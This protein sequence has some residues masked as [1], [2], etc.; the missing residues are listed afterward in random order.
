MRLQFLGAAQQVTGSKTRVTYRDRTYLV[1]CG[2][3][4]G[5]RRLREQNW[6]DL[7]HAGGYAG[8][9]L[10]H[11]HIDHC[12]YLPRLVKQGFHGPIYCTA[13]TAA[14]VR[15]LLADAAHLQEE[16]AEDAN[17]N[18]YS[19]H[20]PALP[21]FTMEDV[22][23]TVRLLRVVPR[24]QWLDIGPDLTCRFLRSGHLLGSSFVQLSFLSGEQSRVVTFSGDLGSERSHIIK[25]PVRITETDYLVM[26]G[27]YGDRVHHAEGQEVA[28]ART[29]LS[30]YA[31]R[32]VLLIP[33]FAVG[34]TQ[35]ILYLINKLEDEGVI[36]HIPLFLDSPMAV[37]ATEIYRQ[38][39][40]DLLPVVD[41][42]RLVSSM[43][44]SRF[45]A[46]PT[47]EESRRLQGRD[48]PMI[49]V[50][51][52]GM[53]TGGRILHHL[54][55]R[56]PHRANGVLFIGYQAPGTKGRLLQNGIDQL[57]IHHEA[58]DVNAEVFS[59]EGFSAHADARE[60]LDWMRALVRPPRRLFLNHGEP[61]ALKALRYRVLHEL[62]WEGVEVPGPGEE[63]VLD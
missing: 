11:A 17:R 10:T 31:R 25:G 37:K 52:A 22:E 2:L 60:I 12:G 8:V 26:E 21:L 35:E 1:D 51:A 5:E 62:G 54:K 16:D 6:A 28:L 30:V 23:R 63:F 55:T 49:I 59:I 14:L 58:I 46:T 20:V 45:K 18:H 27:T 13:G 39:A 19:R 53:L 34:R 32:G 57:R 61:E 38:G 4:Q 47:P 9:F 40:D 33:A 43:D 44:G 3:F 15:V 56:L 41:E 50:S 29:I 24:D 7:P 36:P 48:G 42:G